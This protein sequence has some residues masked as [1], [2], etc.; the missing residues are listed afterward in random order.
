[1]KISKPR[2]L[3]S[4]MILSRNY[5]KRGHKVQA[6]IKPVLRS[7]SFVEL[8]LDGVG[9]LV[10]CSHSDHFNIKPNALTGYCKSAVAVTEVIKSIL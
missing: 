10:K 2:N 3:F 6:K 7:H 5:E 9:S 8:S 1:M 4:A